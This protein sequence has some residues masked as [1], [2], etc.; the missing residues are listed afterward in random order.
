MKHPLVSIGLPVF[1]GEKTV[2][3]AV[4]SILSQDYPNLELLISN[5]GSTDETQTI[6]KSLAK[7]DKRIKYFR[8]DIN[9]GAVWNF[10]RVFELSTGKYFMWIAH[11]DTK[12]ESFVSACVEQLEKDKAAV[13]CS[14]YVRGFFMDGA[15]PVFESNLNSFIGK[16]QLFERYSEALNNFPAVAL[17]GLYRSEAVKQTRLWQKCIASDLVFI[18]ELSIYGHFIQV[19]EFMFNYY[20]REK[21]NTVEQDYRFFTGKKNKPIWYLP[22]VIVLIA[23]FRNILRSPLSR[24]KQIVLTLL[25]LKHFM[26]SVLVKCAVKV[27]RLLLKGRVRKKVLHAIYD[28]WI[29]NINCRA[30]DS[31]VDETRSTDVILGI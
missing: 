8:S 25:L 11:D 14:P 26:G 13:L 27:L 17:Y 21:W 2:V 12:H 3:R 30:L 29:R 19:N 1:N 18:Q 24:F 10:N 6:C 23:N 20:A 9:H 4:Q 5:N 31:Q 7:E 15:T 28:R 16:E 22:I